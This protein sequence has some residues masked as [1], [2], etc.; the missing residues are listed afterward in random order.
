MGRK[1]KT[2]TLN[3]WMN[4]E[5]VGSWKNLSRGV[6]EFR[7][8]ESWL[9]SEN[10]R[11]ISLSMPLAPNEVSYKGEI[12]E[13]FFNN[14]LPDSLDIR[15]RIQ[16]RF[17]APSLQPFDLLKEIGLDCVGAFQFLLENSEPENGFSI[18]GEP[19]DEK[20]IA[21]ILRSVPSSSFPGLDRSDSFRISVAGAQEKTA[22]LFYKG[23]WHIPLG[24][25]PTT[26]IFKLPLGKTMGLDLSSSIENEWLCS[27]I[28]KSF[29]IP[30]ANCEI[31]KFN[32]QKVLIVERFDRKYKNSDQLIRIPMEDMCQ[33]SGI[34]PDQK[35][36]SDGGPGISDI[37]KILLGSENSV[38]DKKTFLKTNIL[39]WLL[40]APDGHAKNFSIFLKKKGRFSLTPIY[41]VISAYPILGKKAFQIAPEKLK[42]AMSVKGKNRHYECN[43]IK[44]RH[45][46]STTD[47]N[48]KEIIEEIFHEI[49]QE[50][51]VVISQTTSIIPSNFPSNI[52]DTI[53]EGLEKSVRKIT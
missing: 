32:N 8:Y 1:A 11:P 50:I 26:H 45:W 40:A 48:S 10:S 29:G 39:F 16:S 20:E 25:T 7:Y 4:G 5:L 51:Q 23:K 42:M 46:L 12:V 33:A 44:K 31:G 3:V 30:T 38:V 47:H 17:R 37:L 35:Y 19:L 2:A 43:K 21:S 18:I 53:L 22:F 15:K 28:M 9:N 41:D 24:T 36:E 6:Q 27:K 52:S 34:S 14:L 49:T 13:N